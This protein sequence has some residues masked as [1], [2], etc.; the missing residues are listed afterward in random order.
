MFYHT[1]LKY[2]YQ[3]E[4]II[5]TKEPVEDILYRKYIKH[6]IYYKNLLLLSFL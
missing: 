4:N 3:V 6:V 5:Q 1:L 2:D